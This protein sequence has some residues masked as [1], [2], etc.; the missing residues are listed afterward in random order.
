[1]NAT[2]DLGDVSSSPCRKFLRQDTYSVENPRTQTFDTEDIP[3][4]VSNERVEVKRKPL[5]HQE[6]FTVKHLPLNRQMTYTIQSATK[7]R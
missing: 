7:N 3:E 1:M 5:I 4:E 2:F 6:T